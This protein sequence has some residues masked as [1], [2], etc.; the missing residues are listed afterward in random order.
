MIQAPIA[1][2]KRWLRDGSDGR[3]FFDASAE[4]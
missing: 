2:V 1:L 4:T 3:K